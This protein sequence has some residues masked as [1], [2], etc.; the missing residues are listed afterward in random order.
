MAVAIALIVVVVARVSAVIHF[1][2]LTTSVRWL[3]LLRRVVVALI[4]VGRI[5]WCAA[6]RRLGLIRRWC[7]RTLRHPSCAVQGTSAAGAFS[8]RGTVT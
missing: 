1:V 7:E 6:A 4:V 3:R 8:A 2:V 5:L